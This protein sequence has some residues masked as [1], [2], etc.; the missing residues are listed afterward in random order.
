MT[1]PMG[2]AAVPSLRGFQVSLLLAAAAVLAV[3]AA[4][5]FLRDRAD[6]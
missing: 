1:L 6:G 5:L 3:L 2:G 4:S